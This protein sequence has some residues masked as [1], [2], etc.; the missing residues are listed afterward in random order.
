VNRVRIY[1]IYYSSFLTCPHKR[2]G[3]FE[4]VTCAS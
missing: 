3:G 2:G 4:L 1:D